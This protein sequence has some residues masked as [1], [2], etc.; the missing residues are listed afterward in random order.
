MNE[1]RRQKGNMYDPKIVFD[2]AVRGPLARLLRSH[3]LSFLSHVKP[4]LPL[5]TLVRIALAPEQRA[6][7]LQVF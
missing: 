2:G 5:P 6:I 3:P 4:E 1:L 7:S